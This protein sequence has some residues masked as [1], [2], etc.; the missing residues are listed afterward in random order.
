MTINPSSIQVFIFFYSQSI[1]RLTLL[2]IHAYKYMLL[3]LLITILITGSFL[4]FLAGSPLMDF[5]RM[6]FEGDEVVREQDLIGQLELLQNGNA[7]GEST[8]DCTLKLGLPCNDPPVVL[9]PVLANASAHHR[10][11]SPS[12]PNHLYM[13]NGVIPS[14]YYGVT[15][16]VHPNQVMMNNYPTMQNQRGVLNAPYN[17]IAIQ[18]NMDPRI[19][20][21]GPVHLAGMINLNARSVD[22]NFRCYATPI[23]MSSI[24][25]ITRPNIYY[26][27][28]NSGLGRGHSPMLAPKQKCDRDINVYSVD[29][30]PDNNMCTKCH[31]SDTPMWRKGPDG[32]KSLCNACGLRF[33]KELKRKKEMEDVKRKGQLKGVSCSKSRTCY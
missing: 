30:E 32:S 23:A 5:V 15:G 17:N 25:G 31:T 26:N 14:T 33:R 28:I 1:A 4:L 12:V 20:R 18:G 6:S 3:F 24:N 11:Y 22:P 27:N 29:D 8:V 7:V 2:A 16:C 19:S 10:R 9:E 13:V 21:I